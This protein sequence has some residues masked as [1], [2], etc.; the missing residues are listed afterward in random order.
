MCY[1]HFRANGTMEPCVIDAKGVATYDNN[2]PIQ[3]E[4]FFI[5]T[6]RT[7]RADVRRQAE[8]GRK[9]DLLSVGGGTGFT[10]G[11]LA[12]GSSLHYPRVFN[13]P[14]T[15]R[16]DLLIRLS[17]AG[18]APF[19]LS[20]HMHEPSAQSWIGPRVGSCAVQG[21]ATAEWSEYTTLRC[22]VQVPRVRMANIV[23]QFHQSGVSRGEELVKIDFFQ[24]VPSTRD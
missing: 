23:L 20:V 8:G 18:T 17:A 11:Q 2:Q 1:V 22:P 6:N 24:F 15:P 16:V 13:L 7:R 12:H 3:A 21:R 4:N 9:E 5:L 19:T 14:A 10:V